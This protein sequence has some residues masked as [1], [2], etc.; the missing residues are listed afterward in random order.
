MLHASS[1]TDLT[2]TKVF[3]FLT[4]MGDYIVSDL[5]L[6]KKSL[7]GTLSPASLAKNPSKQEPTPHE[8]KEETTLQQGSNDAC[9]IHKPVEFQCGCLA[10]LFK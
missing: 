4:G 9:S 6:P 10:I 2:G 7:P 8:P 1:F 3:F 5:Y